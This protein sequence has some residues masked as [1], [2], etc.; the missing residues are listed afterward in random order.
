VGNREAHTRRITLG[1]SAQL[2]A[3]PPNATLSRAAHIGADRTA[4]RW[5]PRLTQTRRE[6][7]AASVTLVQVDVPE[8][9]R[10]PGQE[11][12]RVGL[13]EELD[14]GVNTFCFSQ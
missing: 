11:Q 10:P 3:G 6:R 5:P 7:T 2:T 4:A 9:A 1:P 12:G 13:S 8:A 14:G